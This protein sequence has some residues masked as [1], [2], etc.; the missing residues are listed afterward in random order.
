IKIAPH[1]FVDA[2]AF[3]S[4]RDEGLFF[5]YF[6]GR[7]GTVFSCLSHDVVAHETTHA[8][9]DGLRE[10]YTDPSSPDQ[11]GFHEGFAD[12]VALL[13]VLPQR[14]VVDAVVDRP[15]G[16]ADGAAAR[17]LVAL[18]DVT[19]KALHNSVLFGLAKQ[20]GQEMAS[21]RGHAVRQSA[22]MHPSA[23]LLDEE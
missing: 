6:P 19:P 14:D 5:G 9:L 11:A 2:N 15:A 7:Y 3:Y 12:V 20:M 10:R 21:V 4:R 18:K 13:S 22:K 17:N 1:A 23:R 8:L 16:R